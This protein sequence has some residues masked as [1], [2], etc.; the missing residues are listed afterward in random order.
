MVKGLVHSSYVFVILL[1]E[2]ST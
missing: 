2:S 1:Q